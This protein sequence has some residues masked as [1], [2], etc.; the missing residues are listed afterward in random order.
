MKTDLNKLVRRLK[1]GDASAFDELYQQTYRQVFFI[2]LPILND[3]ALAEDIMQDTYLK[4]L[5]SIHAYEERNFLAYLLT[6]AK[7]LA[8]NE[9][10]KRKR[11]T[12]TDE[13]ENDYSNYSFLNHAEIKLEKEA[14]IKEVLSCLDETEKNVVLLYNVE[15]LTHRE[16]A[17]ILGKPLG[18]I[19]WT[20]QKALKKM[21]KK[22]K[23]G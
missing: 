11:V 9:Y 3:R 6:I 20:Y 4:L 1:H 7:N 10:K 12:Y 8:I 5:D 2:V 18:T 15:N 19:T 22:Y 23:E 13:I 14:L 21:Q 17:M 16:I